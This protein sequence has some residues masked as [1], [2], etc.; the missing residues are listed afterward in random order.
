MPRSVIFGRSAQRWLDAQL[1]YLAERD[2]RAA[3]RLLER[4][5]VAKRQL[6][7]FPN[8]GSRGK[9]AGTRR[10]IIAPYVLTYHEAGPDLLIIVDIRHGRQREMPLP[11]DI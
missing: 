6:I 2:P 10:L 4:L 11:K 9:V 1:D 7:D 8:S 3:E 5:D